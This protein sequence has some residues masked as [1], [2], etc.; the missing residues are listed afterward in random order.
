MVKLAAPET[1]LP[2]GRST[3]SALSRALPTM[4]AALIPWPGATTRE[5]AAAF[6]TTVDG[7]VVGAGNARAGGTPARAGGSFTYLLASGS[8]AFGA[9]P[10][11]A[12]NLRCV[13]SWLENS[14]RTLHFGHLGMSPPRWCDFLCCRS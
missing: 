8:R 3:F 2:A 5:D 7:C 13:T 10:H 4:F 14:N 6:L 9:P 1:E 12:E 11:V